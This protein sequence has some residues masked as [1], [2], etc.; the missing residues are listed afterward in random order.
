M[1]AVLKKGKDP[2]K[3]QSYFLYILDKMQLSRLLLPLGDLTKDEV[4]EI[5]RS[6]GLPAASRPESQEICFIENNDYVSFIRTL[7]PD[8]IRPGPILDGHGKALGTHN[9]IFAYT[10]GQRKGLGALSLEPHFV[11][12]IDASKNTVYVGSRE[13]AMSDLVRVQDI[14]WIT[15]TEQ[16]RIRVDVKIRS[17]MKAVPAEI[18]VEGSSAY[19]RFDQPQWAPAPGQGAVFYDGDILLGGGTITTG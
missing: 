8:M 14:N 10:I 12:R 17:M 7:D 1:G 11:T 15:R 19:V 18:S 9:G 5:A 3:D 2:Q 6:L 16:E 4:R 13:E